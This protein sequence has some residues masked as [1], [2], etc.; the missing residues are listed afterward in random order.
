MSKMRGVTWQLTIVTFLVLLSLLASS[1]S[2]GYSCGDG[3]CRTK[4][5]DES[6]SGSNADN[7]CNEKYRQI[8]TFGEAHDAGDGFHRDSCASSF[9][10]N[11]KYVDCRGR[12]SV[13]TWHLTCPEDSPFCVEVPFYL[14][15]SANLVENSYQ[16]AYCVGFGP[17]DGV[18][19]APTTSATTIST[20]IENNAMEGFSRDGWL[21]N[22]NLPDRAI[23]ESAY[24]VK[25]AC[26]GIVGIDASWVISFEDHSLSS[27]PMNGYCLG[28]HL[29]DFQRSCPTSFSDS[30][31]MFL[32]SPDSGEPIGAITEGDPISQLPPAAL[33]SPGDLA[34]V[35]QTDVFAARSQN[36]FP[37]FCY[38]FSDDENFL[39]FQWH[40]SPQGVPV[41]TFAFKVFVHANNNYIFDFATLDKTATSFS[42]FFYDAADS[43]ESGVLRS[44]GTYSMQAGHN[45]IIEM[46][47]SNDPSTAFSLSWPKSNSITLLTPFSNEFNCND[48]VDNDL[49]GQIDAADTDC[50]N[51][52]SDTPSGYA[53]T[54]M[55]TENPVAGDYLNPFFADGHTS[56]ASV[57]QFGIWDD[58]GFLP[59]AN[60]VSDFVCGDDLVGYDLSSFYPR[61]LTGCLGSLS[62]NAFTGGLCSFL[63]NTAETGSALCVEFG[64]AQ[65]LDFD[66]TQQSTPYAFVDALPFRCFGASG[67]E[68]WFSTFCHTNDASTNSYSGTIPTANL[69][70]NDVS[71]F[72]TNQ[73]FCSDFYIFL[74]TRPDSGTDNQHVIISCNALP[75]CEYSSNGMTEII[76]N[77][78]EEQGLCV[79]DDD[80]GN[81]RLKCNVQAREGCHLEE[82]YLP[83]LLANS[84]QCA[85]ER[86]ILNETSEEDGPYEWSVFFDL[87]ENETLPSFF[88]EPYIDQTDLPQNFN[89]EDLNSLYD[90]YWGY[91]D[92]VRAL[93]YEIG[94]E[95]DFTHTPLSRNSCFT[96]FDEQIPFNT[97]IE[98]GC[99]PHNFAC[100]DPDSAIPPIFQCGLLGDEQTCTDFD[101]F[102]NY[103]ST[104]ELVVE[105]GGITTYIGPDG[106]SESNLCLN[107]LF[108]SGVGSYSLFSYDEYYNM[109]IT[110]L[111]TWWRAGT[112]PFIIHT[113]S[114][115]SFISNTDNWFVCGPEANNELFYPPIAQGADELDIGL[116]Y[117]ASFP[118]AG[119]SESV[120]CYDIL[121][122]YLPEHITHVCQG[123]SDTNCCDSGSVPNAGESFASCSQFCEIDG[124]GNTY[125]LCTEFPNDNLPFCQEVDI[126][127]QPGPE[128]MFS[129]D[130]DDAGLVT[131]LDSSLPTDVSCAAL[132]ENAYFDEAAYV[133][134]DEDYPL[135]RG[136]DLFSSQESDQSTPRYQCCIGETARCEAIVVESADEC[137]IAGG[138]P[139]DE[140]VSL[141]NPF[142]YSSGCLGISVDI[143]GQEPLACCFGTYQNF[144]FG[145][146]EF[147]SSTAFTCFEQGETGR[148]GECCAGRACFNQNEG[149]Y[150]G[151]GSSYFSAMNFDVYDEGFF[152]SRVYRKDPLLGNY[153]PLPRADIIARDWSSFATL[154]F[155]AGFSDPSAIGD[156]IISTVSNYNN[157]DEDNSY[158]IP[159][160]SHSTS[161][162]SSY[163]WHH[164]EVPLDEVPQEILSSVTM[165]FVTT[166][167]PNVQ[168]IFDNFVLE[169]GVGSSLH[170]QPQY[171]TGSWYSWV[172]NLD[173]ATDVG[174]RD[175]ASFDYTSFS[176]YKTA[177]DSILS[178]GWSGRMCCGDDTTLT[179]KEY[180]SDTYA[181]CFG[182]VTI[183]HDRSAAEMY[184]LIDD[185]NLRAIL[186]YNDPSDE[187]DLG[188][189]LV[190]DS[191][192]RND[193]WFTNF[194]SYYGESIPP[195]ESPMQLF[196]AENVLPPF[197][198][199]GSWYCDP[200]NGWT[201]S[202][203]E[204]K[205]DF[206]ATTLLGVVDNVTFSC[207]DACSYDLFCGDPAF[208]AN[209]DAVL[210]LDDLSLIEHICVLNVFET[211]DGGIQDS[212]QVFVGVSLAKP[213]TK[214]LKDLAEH[215]FDKFYLSSDGVTELS[216]ASTFEAGARCDLETFN[217][218][219]SDEEAFYDCTEGVF[220]GMPQLYASPGL[221][222]AILTNDE[223]PGIEHLA[224]LER[225]WDS[226][227]GFFNSL[228]SGTRDENGANNNL[229]FGDLAS[230]RDLKADN[231][232]VRHIYR[233]QGNSMTL[234]AA[235]NA[236][237]Q[238]HNPDSFE[239]RF[240]YDEHFNPEKLLA[241]YA[242]VEEY[243]LQEN[244]IRDFSIEEFPD[245]RAIFITGNAQDALRE[246]EFSWNLLTSAQRMM[247]TTP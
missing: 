92:E 60:S 140:S 100:S 117:G 173:G 247:P 175:A 34:L 152:Q 230:R 196:T 180:F 210:D 50:F 148:F 191:N 119:G 88:D 150:F 79:G 166:S 227:L 234:V 24:G 37:D 154:T 170:S 216:F 82:Q 54:F 71:A 242:L 7:W 98:A 68:E 203:A 22:P 10:I 245:E 89:C 76:Y 106:A 21:N 120:T 59:S 87:T 102:C 195:G 91:Q 172:S 214:T 132:A 107:D 8:R 133:V 72:Y 38:D 189:F 63:Q 176:P 105:Y 33:F 226:F 80:L 104:P 2:A 239:F 181:G 69:F 99:S 160:L 238:E 31:W 192:K 126:I 32:F 11:E 217:K 124:L 182:G 44:S 109:S 145:E 51:I 90:M 16:G 220:N 224:L 137:V 240:V 123:G 43:R 96:E 15:K 81:L 78:S 129:E 202:I 174:F 35:Q 199:R 9:S 138:T 3:N 206:L 228:F 136:G 19:A 12:D 84:D 42:I 218:D 244:R 237:R 197:T 187:E 93:A 165:I 183:P 139:F 207:G 47:G 221:E 201:R 25:A 232:F 121:H 246:K 209:Y 65:S 114:R 55:T 233:D 156:L 27:D 243:Y 125:D 66:A 94:C 213:K 223:I 164:F 61:E 62:S 118:N 149:Y 205:V 48:E 153:I 142:I 6:G 23:L 151:A 4:S 141:E 5:F 236:G 190:C 108:L 70:N 64:C 83:T 188:D 57:P 144:G 204:T 26:E 225:F 14:G 127:N 110:H 112:G 111:P 40:R 208:A 134:C 53:P 36:A 46:Y 73:N 212:K 168:A 58:V 146:D 185:Q 162:A 179:T 143:V 39:D 29:A 116:E 211:A 41:R 130:C 115:E 122:Y 163:R 13:S 215:V 157:L 77:T 229:L 161:G 241:Y 184:N 222:I 17:E 186:Y 178:Y 169:P 74:L 85:F 95:V 103:V 171:C 135:C 97:F 231:F 219:R 67:D 86:C 128:Y 45:Y 155:D 1:V 198:T 193:T 177:C 75:L 56:F 30:H 52:P 200:E 158:R 147:K 18:S 159:L 101:V 113:N 167:S 131:C 235:M 20:N 49:D 28:A 194:F